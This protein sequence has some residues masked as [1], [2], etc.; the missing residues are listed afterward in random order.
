MTIERAVNNTALHR[1]CNKVI[2]IEKHY[3]S[4]GYL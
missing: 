1:E 2:D 3:S 4:I